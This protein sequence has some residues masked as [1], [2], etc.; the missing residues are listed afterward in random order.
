MISEK[1]FLVEIADIILSA[2]DNNQVVLTIS[3]ISNDGHFSPKMLNRKRLTSMGFDTMSRFI[4]YI[5]KALPEEDLDCIFDDLRDYILYVA[6]LQ[7]G[8]VEAIIDAHAGSPIKFK[9][10]KP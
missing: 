5:A 3:D 4:L 1:N 10:I 9:N 6:N 7:D 2:V 8:S